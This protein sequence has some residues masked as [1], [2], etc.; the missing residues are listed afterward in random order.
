[1]A[2]CG[3]SW[4][5]DSWSTWAGTRRPGGRCSTGPLGSSWNGWGW[6]RCPT[7]P[8]WRPTS[9]AT[10]RT[11][12]PRTPARPAEPGRL[13]SGPRASAPQDLGRP[14]P[15]PGPVRRVAVRAGPLGGRPGLDQ[16]EH[17]EAGPAQQPEPLPVRQVER[18]H[19]VRLLDPMEAEVVALEAVGGVLVLVFPHQV[20]ERGDGREREQ[21][22]GPKQSARLGDGPV[23]VGEVERPVV[24]EDHVERCVGERDA[25]PAGLHEREADADGVLVLPGVSELPPG[26]VEADRSGSPSDEGDGPLR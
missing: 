10:A 11:A 5:G 2:C 19:P 20:E 3:P 24:R 15:R 1:M 13:G 18:D 6:P 22:A 21:A 8:R 25:L 9:T 17:L 4:T 26:E 16:V 14:P 7:C 12:R 23:R